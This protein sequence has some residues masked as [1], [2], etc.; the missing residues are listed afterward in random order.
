VCVLLVGLM[1]LLCSAA[2]G[3]DAPI[4]V[5]PAPVKIVTTGG[6]TVIG[7]ETRIVVAGGDAK[8]AWTAEMLSTELGKSLGAAGGRLKILTEK[9]P[10]GAPGAGDIVLGTLTSGA[11]AGKVVTDLRKTLSEKEGAYVMRVSPTGI[12]ILGRDAAGTF[13]GALTLLQLFTPLEKGKGEIVRADVADYP[14]HFYRGMRSGLPRGKPRRGEITIEYYKDM[15]RLM[16]FARLNHVWVQGCSYNV[17]QK[18][19]PDMNWEDVLT[20]EQIRDVV[21][22]ARRHFL[23]MDGGNINYWVYKK[24]YHHLAELYPDETWEKPRK[25]TR[26]MNRVIVCPSNPEA[27]KIVSDFMDDTMELLDGDHFCIALDEMYQEY[28]GARWCACKLCKDK[29][30]VKL[31]AEMANKLIAK[32]LAKGKIPIL[33]GGALMYEH[34]GWYKD[35]Y[36]AIDLVENRDKIIVYNWSEGHIRRGAMYVQLKEGEPRVRLKNPTFS[37][38]PYFKKHGYKNVVHLFAGVKWRGRP[39]MRE[40]NGKLDCYG[41]FVSYY[42]PMNYEVM[43]QRGA[44]ARLAFTGQHLWSPDIPKMDSEEDDRACRYAEAIADVVLAGKSYVEAISAAR[45]AYAAPAGTLVLKGG[46]LGRGF[47]SVSEPVVLFAKQRGNRTEGKM[48]IL[49]PVE[50]ANPGAAYLVLTMYDWDQVGE[51]EI[52]LNGHKVDIAVSRQSNGRDYQFPSVVVP[53]TWLKFGPEPNEM[54][55]VYKSTAGFIIKKAEI[56][57]SDTPAEK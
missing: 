32:A 56:I 11:L 22:F 42:H 12:A 7:P 47:K 2:A 9:E 24:Q 21:N 28:N 37:A 13:H 36:K 51:G 17:P 45:K 14:Y 10:V 34:Q 50:E 6:V 3:K 54:K 4:P 8:L 5:Y 35:I 20:V 1:V 19:H 40:V 52:Y 39:E 48:E 53:S 15:L 33:G 55:F 16:A 57:L 41:G 44:L 18:H 31:W 27:W 30:P 43:K 23:S 26:K 38:T 25:G 49:L 29:D 46:A